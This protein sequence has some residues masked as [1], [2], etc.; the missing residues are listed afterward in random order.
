MSRL[1]VRYLDPAW[2]MPLD[3]DGRSF[4]NLNRP[5]DL[6]RATQL[7]ATRPAALAPG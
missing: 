1:A 6:T 4:L 3:P 7:M 2:W 5:E